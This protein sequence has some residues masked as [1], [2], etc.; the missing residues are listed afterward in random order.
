MGSL[1][2]WSCRGHRRRPRSILSS[3]RV[4]MA[5]T[6]AKWQDAPSPTAKAAFFA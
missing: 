1:V 3:E 4:R 2:P 5:R 6:A